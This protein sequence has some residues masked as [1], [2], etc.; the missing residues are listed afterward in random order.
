[1]LLDCRV[2]RFLLQKFRSEKQQRA[3]LIKSSARQSQFQIMVEFNFSE[4]PVVCAQ[5]Q[6]RLLGRYQAEALWTV[7]EPPEKWS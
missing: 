3:L 4:S 5:S 7:P 6:W 1:V 2:S